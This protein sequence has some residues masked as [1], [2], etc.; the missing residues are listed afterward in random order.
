M[1]GYYRTFTTH[2]VSDRREYNSH[3]CDNEDLLEDYAETVCVVIIIPLPR[4][5]HQ[6][7]ESRIATIVTV[8]IYWKIMQRQCVWLLSY[9]YHKPGI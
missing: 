6:I 4:T 5:R 9:L 3:N 1:C 8:K 7:E 2:P